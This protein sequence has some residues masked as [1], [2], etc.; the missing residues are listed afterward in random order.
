MTRA[1]TGPC[2]IC[3]AEES[4]FRFG[5]PYPGNYFCERCLVENETKRTRKAAAKLP[6]LEKKLA[7]LGG[8]FIFNPVTATQDAVDAERARERETQ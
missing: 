3:G 1:R 4:N 7:A 6:E 5:Y 8:P 2:R